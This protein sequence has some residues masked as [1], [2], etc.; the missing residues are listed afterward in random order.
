MNGE[1]VSMKKFVFLLTWLFIFSAGCGRA[2]EESAI[3]NAIQNLYKSDY[4]YRK[5]SIKMAD[6]EEIRFV[7]E[8]KV[9]QSPYQ[10][11]VAITESA[12]ESVQ[13]ETYYYGN[14]ELVNVLVKV[15][16][17][18]QET[19]AKR[20]RWYGYGEKPEF[21]L[22]GETETNGHAV[23][24]Y[25]AEYSVELSKNYKLK[26]AIEAVVKQRYYMD[27]TEKTLIAME[28]DLTDLNTKT[29]IAN[30]IANNG[31]SMEQAQAEAAEKNY[32]ETERVEF[33]N[34]N[35]NFEI[36]GETLG[37]P[38]LKTAEDASSFENVSDSGELA[39]GID[40]D[41]YGYI[42][43]RDL[44]TGEIFLL[45]IKDSL[46]LA[47]SIEETKWLNNDIIAVVSH[48]NPSLSCLLV[49]DAR[50]QELLDERY[51]VSF[52]WANEDQSSLYYIVPM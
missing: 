11:Y 8:G 43:I 24:V 42:K 15:N 41:N 26:E 18:W 33:W 37:I 47:N 48:V 46:M 29:A 28:T 30:D 1:A 44:Q 12:A 34:Y 39:A 6:D 52:E 51:G 49:Y 40:E 5:I 4:E 21:T 25:A 36:F 31:V 9:I 16:G 2:T 32:S 13:T 20:K 50:T 19:K 22:E 17:E 45:E 23:E 3:E 14:G 10:E 27:K 38:A 7:M 35:G